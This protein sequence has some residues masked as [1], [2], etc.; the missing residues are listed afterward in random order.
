MPKNVLR[1]AVKDEPT[2]KNLI[3]IIYRLEKLTCKLSESTEGDNL[4]K[5]L[6]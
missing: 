4:I 1:R 2:G 3:N 5:C 6:K